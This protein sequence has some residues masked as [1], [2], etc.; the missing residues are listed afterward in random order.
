MH[1]SNLLSRRNSKLL[2]RI[3]SP[4]MSDNELA[5]MKDNKRLASH[6]HAYTHGINSDPMTMFAILFSA[7]IHDVDHPGVSNKQF[8]E[9]HPLIGERYR[10]K[11]VAEQNSLDVAWDVLMDSR[12]RELREYVFETATELARFRQIV[13]N[14]VLATDIFDPELNELR[15][16][17]WNRAFAESSAS[18][19]TQDARATVVI[20]HI[21]QAS[22]VCHTMQHWHVY[23]RHNKNLFEEILV[24]YRQGRCAANPAEFWYEG[25]LKFF[26]NYIIPLAQKLKDCNVFGVSSDECLNYALRNRAEWADRGRAVVAEYIQA[27]PVGHSVMRHIN[28]TPFE[29]EKAEEV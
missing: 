15:K 16:K 28:K 20:E 2:K 1:V 27:F 3:V 9:E 21:M 18:A 7:I 6:L 17:R 5:K 8:S 26:D 4:E 22:D 11:S 19:D 29:E 23:Q 12:F 14:T 24:A 25:E 13:V 10:H